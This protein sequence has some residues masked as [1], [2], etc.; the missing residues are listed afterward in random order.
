[1]KQVELVWIYTNEIEAAVIYSFIYEEKRN[2]TSK[3]FID[4]IKE[5]Y[6]SQKVSSFK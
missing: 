3:N 5:T 1:M 6:K 4:A 2:K